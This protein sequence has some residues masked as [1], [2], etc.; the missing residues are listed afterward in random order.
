MKVLSLLGHLP[1]WMLTVLAWKMT[2]LMLLVGGYRGKVV[3]ANLG[4]VFS[5][6]SSRQRWWMYA[7]FQRHFAQL[8]VESA[9]LFS[10]RREDVDAGMVHEGK[11]VMTQLPPR[12]STFLLPVGT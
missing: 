10:M 9:K 2:V 6:L 12:A 4:K 1:R 7:K 11:D 8:M 3:R 5:H